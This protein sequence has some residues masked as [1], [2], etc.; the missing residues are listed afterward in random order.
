[1]CEKEDL[2]AALEVVIPYHIYECEDCIVSFAVEQ[3]FEDQSAVN[4]PICLTDEHI[5]DVTSGQMLLRR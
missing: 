5:R 3:A 2:D 1:V 4:C